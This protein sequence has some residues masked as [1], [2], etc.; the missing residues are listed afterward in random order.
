MRSSAHI[1]GHP[2]HPMLIPFPFAYLFGNAAIDVWARA[3]G[4]HRWY[5]TASHMNLL[6]LGSAL[7]AAV[8]GI[9]DY[10][11]AVPPRSSARQRATNH[12]FANLSA[13][14][15]FAAARLGR[16]RGS[17]RPSVPRGASRVRQGGF[18]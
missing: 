1:N 8:P 16:H 2:L 5:R 3:T 9:V 7:V 15:L 12:M 14:A 4:R 13:V 11:F 17:S 18:R 10:V 6:G